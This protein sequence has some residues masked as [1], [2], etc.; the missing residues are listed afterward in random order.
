MHGW[1]LVRN[2]ALVTCRLA[3]IMGVIWEAWV[4]DPAFETRLCLRGALWGGVGAKLNLRY[5]SLKV[6][7]VCYA[8]LW[9]NPSFVP[10]S[11]LNPVV[12][13]HVL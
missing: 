5:F 3:H 9:V 1:E 6:F 11:D 13:K 7:G 4:K 10:R 8:R 2:S 12:H